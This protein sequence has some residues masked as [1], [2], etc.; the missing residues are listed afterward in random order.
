MG[1]CPEVECGPSAMDTHVVAAMGNLCDTQV[2]QGFHR[3]CERALNADCRR[4]RANLVG[5]QDANTKLIATLITIARRARSAGVPLE[6][7]VSDR[8]RSWI[9]LYRLEQ[10]LRPE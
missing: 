3:R 9:T 5:V 1:D 6:L 4:I 10:V 7:T 8:M 2:L